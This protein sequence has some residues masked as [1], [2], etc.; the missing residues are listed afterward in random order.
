MKTNKKIKK[1]LDPIS[2]KNSLIKLIVT[3]SCG[4]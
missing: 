1:L 3:S 4:R 2:K